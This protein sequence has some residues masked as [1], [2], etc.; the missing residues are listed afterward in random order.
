MTAP[1]VWAEIQRQRLSRNYW[2]MSRGARK[3]RRDRI[4]HRYER[5]VVTSEAAEYAREIL[6]R[7]GKL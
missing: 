7:R 2:S 3:C 5:I 4:R 1:R 6:A